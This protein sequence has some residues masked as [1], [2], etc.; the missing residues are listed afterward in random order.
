MSYSVDWV[1]LFR[2]SARL[3]DRIFKGADP[4]NIPVEQANVYELVLNLRTARTLGLTI[5]AAVLLQAT[6]EIE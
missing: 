6:R 1:A 2:R 4:S 5:P 3:V